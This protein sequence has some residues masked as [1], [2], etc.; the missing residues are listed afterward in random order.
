M[1]LPSLRHSSLLLLLMAGGAGPVEG[2]LDRIRRRVQRAAEDEVGR[3]AEAMTRN[4]VRCVV[5]DAACAEKARKD[6]KTA[7]FT[8]AEGQ[9][10]LDD[11]GRP[12]TDA[13]DASRA[14]DQPGSGV[15][16]N[17]DY[18]PGNT[19]W[20]ALDLAREPIGRFPAKQ[21]T[22]V[23]GN[24]QTVERDSARVLEFTAPTTIVVPLGKA[25]PDDF[26][27][28]LDFQA[29]A[30]NAALVLTT[31][32]TESRNMRTY[33]G[34]YL[35]L[36]QVSGIA[37]KGQHRS[38]TAGF[39]HIATEPIAYRFQVDGGPDPADDYAI[40]Y[41]GTERAAQL[42]AGEFARGDA[43]E[44]HVPATQGRPAYISRLV[45]AVHGA[46]LYQALD[47]DGSVT[48]R[49]ILFDFDSDRLRAESTPTLEQLYQA[50]EQHPDLQIT[51]EG[52]TDAL[53][54]TAYNQQL[55]ERRAAAV[56][57]YLTKRGIAPTRL[58]AVGKGE[59]E[60]VGGNATEAEREQNRRVV[61]IKRN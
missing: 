32:R 60:P 43:I 38:S 19:V 55:S 28:E 4:A 21:L 49:G 48:T 12:V 5:G 57:A 11:K 13:R 1:R 53:G 34:P 8:D 24:A 59:S 61:I 30:P 42:P 33:H 44:I 29:S 10:I 25:L 20:Y 23:S 37:E 9:V 15:W 7:V 50:L 41:A 18:V 54:G 31:S 16:R 56:T 47:R 58:Q 27:I 26:T 36:Y 17:Y 2:Q 6:G 46:P 40:L 39:W 52:H 45:V 14:A 35:Y 22:F 3:K 51:I